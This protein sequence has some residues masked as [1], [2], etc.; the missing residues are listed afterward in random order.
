MDLRFSPPFWIYDTKMSQSHTSSKKKMCTV[1]TAERHIHF[2]VPFGSYRDSHIWC[3]WF[4]KRWFSVKTVK[5]KHIV[6]VNPLRAASSRSIYNTNT[7]MAAA[8]AQKKHQQK[9]KVTVN[10]LILTTA[11]TL[12]YTSSTTTLSYGF[13]WAFNET[14]SLTRLLAVWSL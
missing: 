14:T 11:I 7:N 1:V 8:S 5:K 4:K 2:Y 6:F 10:L 3:F 13:W 9:V 12:I